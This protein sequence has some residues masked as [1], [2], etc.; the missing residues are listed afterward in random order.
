MDTNAEDSLWS[1]PENWKPSSVPG[2]TPGLSFEKSQP[3]IANASVAEN[4][5]LCFNVSGTETFF[6]E[7]SR[8]MKS[9]SLFESW[10][11]FD[12][13][14]LIDTELLCEEVL[15]FRIRL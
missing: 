11:V 15:F 5:T 9:W 4:G 3:V 2:G 8:D 14:I 13:M 6:I 1:M 7:V 10:E 12:G